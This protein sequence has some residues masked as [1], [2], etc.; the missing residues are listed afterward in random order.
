MRLILE[1][2]NINIKK[3]G[4]EILS[5]EHFGLREGEIVA[6]IGP[7]GAGKSTLLQVLALL[8][9]PATGQVLFHGQVA[10]KNNALEYRRRMAVVFQEALLLNTTVFNNVA[11]GL[12]LRGADKKLISGRV[13]LWLERLGV[14]HL[15]GRMPS[16][17][18]GGEAQR[19]NIARA[20]A[21]EPEVLFLDEPFTALDYPTR[22]S[23][24]KEMGG[25]L[26]ESR[27]TVF[28][29]T[30]DYNEIPYLTDDTVVM[31]G[32]G[33]RHRGSASQLFAGGF[34]E[35]FKSYYQSSY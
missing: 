35:V 9:Q 13:G 29:V 28:F 26:K 20:M 32:G 18:S 22:I 23:L 25:I 27:T 10:G 6:V 4:R 12:K 8:Q 14:S 17:L 16:F 5:V 7:N 30:H 34:E 2:K 11:Q 33:V 19:V 24:L 15:A 21:L 31:A 3:R 1:A